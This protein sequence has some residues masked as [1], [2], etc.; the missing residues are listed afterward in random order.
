MGTLSAIEVFLAPGTNA[1]EF[2]L[3]LKNKAGSVEGSFP[4]PEGDGNFTFSMDDP[5][6]TVGECMRLG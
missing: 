3:V 6:P 4:F 2:E 5:G 1:S